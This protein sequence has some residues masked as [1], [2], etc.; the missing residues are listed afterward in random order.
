MVGV[1]LSYRK[2]VDLLNR[3]LHRREDTAIKISTYRDFCER[4]GK[5]IEEQAAEEAKKILETYHFD[6]ES[7]K[8]TESIAAELRESADPYGEEALVEE[9]REINAVRPLTEEQVKTRGW[10]IERPAQT[11]YISLDEIGVKHQK[12][13][14]TADEEKTG[15]YVWNTVADIETASGSH[16]VYW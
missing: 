10:E 16:M 13:H 9:I 3:V 5:R 11:C 7:G 6:G 1:S 2:G 12:E 15:V 14:R 8:E 4:T